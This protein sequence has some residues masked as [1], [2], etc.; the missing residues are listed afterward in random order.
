[1]ADT[2]LIVPP[3][4]VPPLTG[5]APLAPEGADVTKNLFTLAWW[6]FFHRLSVLVNSGTGGGGGGGGGAT[7]AAGVLDVTLIAGSTVTIDPTAPATDTATLSVFVKA[8][9]PTAVLAWGAN[10]KWGPTEFD[11]TTDTWTVFNLV[12]RTDPADATLKWFFVGAAV[13]GQPS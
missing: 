8:K 9:G 11:S 13:T 1:M 3:Q 6:L 10:V 2:G 4:S 5:V 7:G 12:A